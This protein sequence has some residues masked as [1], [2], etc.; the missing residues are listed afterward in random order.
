MPSLLAAGGLGF[1]ACGLYALQAPAPRWTVFASALMLAAA[2][3]AGGALI[4]FLFALPRTTTAEE[5]PPTGEAETGARLTAPHI[6]ANTNLEQIS[7]W[8]T[9]ILVGVTLVQLGTIGSGAA[10]L[11]RAI[12]PALG[13]QPQSA[14]FGGAV[15]SYFAVWGF[16][17]AWLANRLLLGRLML[18]ADL[19]I[20]QLVFGIEAERRGHLEEAIGWY[21]GAASLAAVARDKPLQEQAKLRAS[22]VTNRVAAQSTG[23]T[24][25]PE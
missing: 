11:F 17:G 10:K 22:E 12:A 7:D 6:R 9:K 18:K 14:A 4:G 19:A 5:S 25:P 8:L 3:S 13:G 21:S 1:L 2:S 16:L 20:R 23:R 15:I 24:P